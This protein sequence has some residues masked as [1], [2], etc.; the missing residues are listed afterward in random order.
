MNN[1]YGLLGS[2]SPMGLLGGQPT[3]QNLMSQYLQSLFM[4]RYNPPAIAQQPGMV[5]SQMGPGGMQYRAPQV[6]NVPLLGAQSSPAAT[7]NAA[8]GPSR[9]EIWANPEQYWQWM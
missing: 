6:A 3:T 9:A 1:F 5:S 8:Q 2:Q 7:Q 4:R